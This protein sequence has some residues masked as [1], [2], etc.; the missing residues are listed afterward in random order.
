MSGEVVISLLFFTVSLQ[1][2]TAGG[3]RSPGGS[4]SPSAGPRVG[5]LPRW[6][7]GSISPGLGGGL[8]W[9]PGRSDCRAREGGLGKGAASGVT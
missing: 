3:W 2:V 4:Y 6:C 8:G 7:L 5:F 1:P 9:A